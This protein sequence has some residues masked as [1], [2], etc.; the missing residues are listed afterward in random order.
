MVWWMKDRAA[1]FDALEVALNALLDPYSPS[2][3]DDRAYLRR[4]I[5]CLDVFR[6]EEDVWQMLKTVADNHIQKTLI[7]ADARYEEIKGMGAAGEELVNIEDQTNVSRQDDPTVLALHP[8]SYGLYRFSIDHAMCDGV[9]MDIDQNVYARLL[10][11]TAKGLNDE[12]QESA[13]DVLKSVSDLDISAIHAA[14]VKLPGR[15]AEKVLEYHEDGKAFPRCAHILDVIRYSVTCD[16]P[17]QILNCKKAI[18]DADCYK[19]ARIKN[20]FHHSV[21]SRQYLGYRDLIMNVV[22]TAGGRSI[23]GEVQLVDAGFMEIQ[24]LTHKLYKVAQCRD[25]SGLLQL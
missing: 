6:F 15:C 11:S 24:I 1:A 16:S 10:C 2:S 4:Y 14:P 22:F 17:Q 5:V 8:D 23:I 3:G 25:P 20:K 19:L 18:E 12:F 9:N 7:Q 21:N 13:Y